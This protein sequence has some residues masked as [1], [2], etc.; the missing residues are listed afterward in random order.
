MR[1]TKLILIPIL[2]LALVATGCP[3]KKITLDR[4][5][6]VLIAAT[7]V[8]IGQIEGL[9][10]A[11]KISVDKAIDLT[12]QGTAIRGRAETFRDLIANIGEVTSSN[13]RQI[14]DLSGEFIDFA[15]DTLRDPEIAK[16]HP[17]TKILKILRDLRF[18]ASQAKL[19]VAILF[20]APPAGGDVVAENRA[21]AIPR[22]FKPSAIVIDL[23]K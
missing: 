13:V 16:L 8:Y 4:V 10:V 6:A 18:G 19:A 17:D 7:D 11:G 15:D 3:A 12:K 2:I 1:K 9:R 20:P 22:A 14:V 23:E 5:G 21:I